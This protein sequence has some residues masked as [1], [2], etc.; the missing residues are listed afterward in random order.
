MQE[1]FDKL[2]KKIVGIGISNLK[3]LVK[4]NDANT[5]GEYCDAT[6]YIQ[7]LMN[8][9][10]NIVFCYQVSERKNFVKVVIVAKQF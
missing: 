6:T 10:V 7:K 3:V 1:Q 9:N 4:V 5:L 2:G 8:K